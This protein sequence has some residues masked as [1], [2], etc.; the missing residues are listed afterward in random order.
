MVMN[1]EYR[2]YDSR[3]SQA[4]HLP[5]REIDRKNATSMIRNTAR[6]AWDV[7][8]PRAAI[9]GSTLHAAQQQ[10]Q[11]VPALGSCQRD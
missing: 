7:P 9:C 5:G 1:V 11:Y 3:A 10:Y 8:A 2:R 6:V 4:V